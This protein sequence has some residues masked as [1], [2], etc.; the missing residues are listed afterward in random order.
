MKLW[1][2]VEK[3]AGKFVRIWL[4]E[5]VL[6]GEPKVEFEFL[7]DGLLSE[8]K[9]FLNKCLNGE[10]DVA[11]HFSKFDVRSGTVFQKLVW[12]KIIDIPR[13][14]TWSY[15]DLAEEIGRPLSSRAVANACAKNPFAFLFPC[16]RVIASNKGLGGYFYDKKIKEVLLIWEGM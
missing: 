16:H 9:N 7:G 10:L 11:D 8:D 15:K 3:I 4:E 12:R 6:T 13:G 14:E 1:V 5:Y 2:L